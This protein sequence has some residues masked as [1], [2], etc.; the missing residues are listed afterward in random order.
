MKKLF[1]SLVCLFASTI[2]AGNCSYYVIAVSGDKN[3]AVSFEKEADYISMSLTLVSNQKDTSKQFSEIKQLQDM[4]IS[5]AKEVSGIEIHKGPI[6]LS[7]VASFS[8]IGSYSPHFRPS[9]AQLNILARMDDQTDIY[10]SANRIQDFLYSIKNLEK[11]D[12]TL[13][14]IQL[15]VKNP[16]DY[17]QLILEKISKDIAF[18]K[19]TMKTEGTITLTGL[20]NPV[21]IR[22]IDDR[23]VELFINYSMAIELK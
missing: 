2:Y 18:I 14:E 20:G 13:G 21:L 4:I 5:K 22:Q 6:T 17:R 19:S 11:D 9:T 16:E 15:V 10:D 7:A 1:V 8:K 3:T 12:Y 23:K